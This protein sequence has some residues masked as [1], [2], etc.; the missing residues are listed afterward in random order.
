MLI[1][2]AQLLNLVIESLMMLRKE[3]VIALHVMSNT[4]T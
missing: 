1:E 4:C 3:T 2:V